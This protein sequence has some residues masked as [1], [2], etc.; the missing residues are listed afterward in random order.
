MQ[1]LT[2]HALHYYKQQQSHTAWLHAAAWNVGLW[3]QQE[4]IQCGYDG[5]NN[6]KSESYWHE[7]TDGVKMKNCTI[8]HLSVVVNISEVFQKYLY[9]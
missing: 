6:I 9:V 8:K 2:I 3:Y 1:L 5:E 7:S 4:H